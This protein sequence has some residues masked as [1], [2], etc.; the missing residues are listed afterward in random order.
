MSMNYERYLR[1][2]SWKYV[3]SVAIGAS[4]PLVVALT[5][6]I[7]EPKISIAILL[8]SA[9]V[10]VG[11]LSAFFISRVVLTPEEREFADRADYINIV[12]EYEE[13]RAI[14]QEARLLYRAEQRSGKIEQRVKELTDSSNA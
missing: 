2:T 8:V 14:E 7:Y 12:A 10:V 1:Q 6:A 5:V 3:V 13:N 4:I 11:A 9:S